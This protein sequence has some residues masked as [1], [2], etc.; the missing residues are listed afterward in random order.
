MRRGTA[1]KELSKRD[2]V[3]PSPVRAQ[4]W[5]VS[6]GSRKATQAISSPT[7]GTIL[8]KGKNGPQLARASHCLAPGCT[9]N[10]DCLRN[11]GTI[12]MCAQQERTNHYTLASSAT[13]PCTDNHHLPCTI[14][15]LGGTK[16]QCV[17]NCDFIIKITKENKMGVQQYKLEE[18]FIVIITLHICNPNLLKTQISSREPLS[19]IA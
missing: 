4:L 9:K 14:F 1:P 2:L 17:F 11:Q 10:D 3:K 7:R 16:V 13:E 18:T 12:S 6:E 19:H 5:G 8:N 15:S